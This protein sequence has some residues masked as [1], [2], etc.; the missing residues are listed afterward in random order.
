MKAV[1]ERYEEGRTTLANL[2]SYIKDR[3][4]IEEK[5]CRGLEKLNLKATWSE[6]GHVS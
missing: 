5:Y 2:I 4:A 6:K 1:T 3:V